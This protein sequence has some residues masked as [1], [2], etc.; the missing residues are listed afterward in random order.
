MDPRVKTSTADLKKQSEMSMRCYEAYHELQ[1]IRE[2]IDQMGSASDAL[3]ALRGN[4]APGN[5][6]TMY[7]SIRESPI[8][9]ETVVGLQH[10]CLFVLNLLQGADVKIP[11]Q[12]IEAVDI[13]EAALDGVKARWDK[14]K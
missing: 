6:N 1:T 2:A 12:S 7:G 5:P 11:K 4:G 9:Q 10:K 13:L 3:K 14:L 8:D